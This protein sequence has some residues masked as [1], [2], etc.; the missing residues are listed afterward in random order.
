M[1]SRGLVPAP[2]SH[3]QFTSSFHPP[4][5]EFTHRFADSSDL[6]LHT[7]WAPSALTSALPKLRALVLPE[8]D[9]GPVAGNGQCKTPC[10][11][12]QE[13]EPRDP[14]CGTEVLQQLAG[15]TAGSLACL[16]RL[17]CGLGAAITNVH[18]RLKWAVLCLQWLLVHQGMVTAV[19]ATKHH[20]PITPEG[21]LPV[22]QQGFRPNPQM[23]GG[24]YDLWSASGEQ[25]LLCLWGGWSKH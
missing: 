2:L 6:A 20:Y 24:L 22:S 10:G 14:I 25:L 17:V 8:V 1:N 9:A 23:T 13:G 4:P 18:I 3:L 15:G 7:L 12:T 16:C 5:K 19:K 11:C 21:A